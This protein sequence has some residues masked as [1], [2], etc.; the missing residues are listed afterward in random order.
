LEARLAGLA[1]TTQ[2]GAGDAEMEWPDD[3]DETAFLS[4]AVSR[5]EPAAPAPGRASARVIGEALPPLEELV[6]RVPP[7]VL[8]ALDDLFRAKFTGVRRISP[9]GNAAAAGKS[10]ARAGQG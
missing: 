2:G 6:A 10:E 3:A 7:A 1:G 8:A 4:E 5:G 9:Q